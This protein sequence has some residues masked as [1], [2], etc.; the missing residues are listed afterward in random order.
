M[1]PHWRI[2]AT[3]I[4]LGLFCAL[5]QVARAAVDPTQGTSCTAM[6]SGPISGST[7]GL[8]VVQPGGGNNLV[9]ISGTW[10]Y[11]QY[12]LG[13]AAASAGSSCSGYPSGALRYNTTLN[14]VEVCNGTNWEFLAASTTSCGTPSGLSFTNVT[15]ASLST[16]YTSNSATITFT[17][18][19]GGA[20]SVSVSGAATAQIS[21]NGGAWGTSGAI[22]S[23]QTLQVR[24]TSSGSVSTT[25][26]AT[27]TVG[28]SS[29]NWTVTTLSGTLIAFSTT[30]TY[31]GGT[32]G[33]L[34]AADAICQS[35]ANTAG[36]AGTFKAIISDGS[37]SAAS[38]L[39]TLSYPIV[40]GFDGT[41]IATTNLWV[42][43]L[44]NSI[45]TPSGVATGG[46]WTGSTA[47]GAISGNGT[48]SSWTSTGVNGQ[49][50]SVQTPGSATWI[51]NITQACTASNRLYC[52]QE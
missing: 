28:G 33:S 40:N 18:C 43:A 41:T 21:V 19:S 14:N 37:T 34:A 11:P 35:E 49:A 24:L 5:P 7:D 44:S 52:V 48:C 8:S 9:C 32:I 22:S 30:S 2:A 13:T 31:V 6:A 16:V 1:L 25:L 17:G 27:V 26:T 3:L 23:G 46:V 10:Q 50:G 47:A 12:V 20:L 45:K 4:L 38:H 15:S 29:T 51:A 39:T 36:Y 42:G